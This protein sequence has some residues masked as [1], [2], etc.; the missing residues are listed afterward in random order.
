MISVKSVSKIYNVNNKLYKALDNINISFP[1]KGLVSIFGRSG[2]GKTT[3]LNII[4]KHETVSEGEVDSNFS[5]DCAPIVF[6][7][8]QLIEDLDVAYVNR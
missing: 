7:D 2:S 3:L 4:A 6:Q 8:A 5:Y 1:N